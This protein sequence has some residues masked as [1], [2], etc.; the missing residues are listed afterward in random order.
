MD[1]PPDIISCHD[2]LWRERVRS[3]KFRFHN[4][5]WLEIVGGAGGANGDTEVPL[6]PNGTDEYLGGDE[7][8]DKYFPKYSIL[9]RQLFF[10]NTFSRIDGVISVAAQRNKIR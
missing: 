1:G 3:E 10:Q 8:R 6:Q 4:A 7:G 2:D 9:F 5:Q